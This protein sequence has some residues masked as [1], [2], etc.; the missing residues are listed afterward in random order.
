VLRLQEWLDKW[1]I[2]DKD[3]MLYVENWLKRQLY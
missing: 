3:A 1:L 2:L